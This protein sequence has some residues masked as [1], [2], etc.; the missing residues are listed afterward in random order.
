MIGPSLRPRGVSRYSTVGGLEGITVRSTSPAASRS[1]RRSDSMRGEMPATASAN[2][3]KRIAPVRAAYRID[4]CQRRSRRSA[5]WRTSSGTGV[6]LREMRDI[7]CRLQGAVEDLLDGHHRVEGHL[8]TDLLGDLVQV[9]AVAL[10]QAHVG[11]A[12]GV[13]GQRLLL[14]AADRQHATL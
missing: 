9:A 10:R 5:V 7:A 14:K 2:S 12:R 4:S 6:H 3:L 8:L 11:Q 13:R 1:R